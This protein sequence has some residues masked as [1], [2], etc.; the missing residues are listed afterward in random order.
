MSVQIY[1]EQC[2]LNTDP[3]LS[4]DCSNYHCFFPLQ[5][6]LLT[7]KALASSGW[8]PSREQTGLGGNLRTHWPTVPTGDEGVKAQREE[9]TAQVPELLRAGVRTRTCSAAALQLEKELHLLLLPVVC[10]SVSFLL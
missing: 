10:H 6:Q 1:E 8:D 3:H 5:T 2:L 9:M 7:W 4:Q